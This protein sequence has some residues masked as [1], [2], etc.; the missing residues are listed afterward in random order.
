MT[1][2]D[3]IRRHIKEAAV[4]LEILEAKHFSYDNMFGGEPH[5]DICKGQVGW[6]GHKTECPF[7][8]I[9]CLIEQLIEKEE[10]E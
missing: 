10:G 8:S 5:C 7:Y 4:D 6:G 1:T 2:W 9:R 3:I